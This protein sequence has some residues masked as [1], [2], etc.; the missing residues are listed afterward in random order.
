MSAERVILGLRSDSGRYSVFT[1]KRVIK[2]DITDK[3]LK[4]P[5]LAGNGTFFPFYRQMTELLM[6]AK[7]SRKLLI[8]YF[9]YIIYKKSDFQSLS[10]VIFVSFIR[11]ENA[12]KTVLNRI[13]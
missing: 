10:A 7:S 2:Y 11:P 5:Y 3:P 8:R 9:D 12:L 4:S 6:K 13:F 1:D